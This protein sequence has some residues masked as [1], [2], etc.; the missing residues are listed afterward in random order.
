VIRVEDLKLSLGDSDSK[1]KFPAAWS[2]CLDNEQLAVVLPNELRFVLPK[3]D[4][5][6]ALQS[7][8]TAYNCVAWSPSSSSKESFLLA[9]INNRI[10][11]LDGITGKLITSFKE[12]TRSEKDEGGR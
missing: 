6:S 1:H 2:C 3:V 4:Q 12:V 10:D 9:A 8:K 5:V 7:V 11:I